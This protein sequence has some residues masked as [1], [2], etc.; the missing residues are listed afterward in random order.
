MPGE[1]R[2][3]S[4]CSMRSTHGSGVAVGSSEGPAGVR[5]AVRRSASCARSCSSVSP[6]VDE[7][8]ADAALGEVVA[9]ETSFALTLMPVEARASSLAM[10][11]VTP[12]GSEA[13]Q[14][15]GCSAAFFG[16]SYFGFPPDSF[17]FCSSPPF[18]LS[19]PA[20]FLSPAPSA[21]GFFFSNTK[22]KQGLIYLLQN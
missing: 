17:F 15:F 11:A 4:P 22:S 6:R 1:E 5:S 16:A 3:D 13:S 18:F 19:F 10:S 12:S 7:V 9:E 20:S 8:A 14:S 2:L 21:A